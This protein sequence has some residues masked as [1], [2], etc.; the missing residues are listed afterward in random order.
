MECIRLGPRRKVG[1]K[2]DRIQGHTMVMLVTRKKES[3]AEDTEKKAQDLVSSSF[4]KMY[5]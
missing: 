1:G 5:M 2:T 3:S 4:P